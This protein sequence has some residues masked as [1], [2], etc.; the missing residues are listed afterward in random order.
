MPMRR[1]DDCAGD[2]WPTPEW[3]REELRGRVAWAGFDLAAKLDLTAWC[4][5]LPGEPAHLLWRFWLPEAAVPHLDK[6]TAGSFRRWCDDGWITVTEGNVLDYERVYADVTADARHFVIAGGDGDQWSMAPVVQELEHRASVPEGFV[7]YNQT[8]ER[9]TPGMVELMGLVEGRRVAHHGNPVARWCFDS[10]EVRRARY[11]PDLIRPDKPER[12]RSGK[13]IDA[14][15][16]AAMAVAAWS[17]RGQLT[18]QVAVP[19]RIY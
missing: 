19:R 12:G 7:T 10:V 9:M 11:N 1:W 2:V 16:A 17:A 5:L 18:A 13:R 8:F 6:H 14:V 3:G 4:L 15:P